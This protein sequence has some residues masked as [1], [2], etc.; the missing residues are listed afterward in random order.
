MPPRRARSSS[1]QTALDSLNQRGTGRAKSPSDQAILDRLNSDEEEDPRDGI[2][3]REGLISNVVGAGWEAVKDYELPLMDFKGNTLRPV[4]DLPEVAGNVAEGISD[5]FT[6]RSLDKAVDTFDMLQKA[7]QDPEIGYS[8]VAAEV[9][10]ALIKAPVD[11][12]AGAIGEFKEHP[13]SSTMA[14]GLG[15]KAVGSVVKGTKNAL[16][17]GSRRLVAQQA[18]VREELLSDIS[19]QRRLGPNA[20]FEYFERGMKMTP[21]ELGSSVQRQ[22]AVDLP[23]AS[24]EKHDIE[25]SKLRPPEGGFDALALLV[26]ANKRLSA[27][28]IGI[29]IGQKATRTRPNKEGF[30][31]TDSIISA[32]RMAQQR[33]K[34]IVNLMND[35]IHTNDLK[36]IATA[37]RQSWNQIAKVPA[38][39]TDVKGLLTRVWGKY[40]GAVGDQVPGYNKVQGAASARM[41]ALAAIRSQLFAQKSEAGLAALEKTGGLD[42]VLIAALDHVYAPNANRRV[43][44]KFI[45]DLS[46]MINDEL[47][48]KTNIKRLAGGIRV[49]QESRGF[50]RPITDVGVPSTSLLAGMYSENIGVGV[51][52]G[53]LGIVGK[54]IAAGTVQQP[55]VAMQIAKGFGMTQ[56]VV[57]EIGRR[58]TKAKKWI[59]SKGGSRLKSFID[60]P[61]KI[62]TSDLY[63]GATAKKGKG[64]A[65]TIGE[66]ID[67]KQKLARE[68]YS[69]EKGRQLRK[70]GELA[71]DATAATFISAGVAWAQMMEENLQGDNGFFE[72]I[73]RQRRQP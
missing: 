22:V 65:R 24:K 8:G 6:G 57:D 14:I 34:N 26:E 27:P 67:A 46:K 4:G 12:V 36:A 59:N 37:F 31:F 3:D 9:G 13:I 15:P 44:G 62:K 68:S 49:A 25:F 19:G 61:L 40:R 2:F 70:I 17:A 5:F 21:E 29:K 58:I 18:G 48:V 45:D 71:P 60:D 10:K 66:R 28:D 30:D 7:T 11:I 38:R 39:E 35:A 1:G 32:D 64:R 47:G 16:R 42:K 56:N 69:S 43:Q 20:E 33:V 55:R 23:S 53:V 54:I 52:V 73:G 50:L 51:A 63:A 41:D 72:V